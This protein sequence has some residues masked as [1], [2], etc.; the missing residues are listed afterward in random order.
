M[1]HRGILRPTRSSLSAVG[2]RCSEDRNLYTHIAPPLT[3][4]GV[5]AQHERGIEDTKNSGE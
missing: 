4:P 5:C 2:K 1:K 3:K